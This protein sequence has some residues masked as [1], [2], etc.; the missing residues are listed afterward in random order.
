MQIS[1][2]RYLGTTGFGLASTL[3]VAC[4]TGQ[5]SGGEG[6]PKPAA[7]R[8]AIEWWSGWGA[9]GLHAD[10]FNKVADMANQVDGRSY[11]VHYTPQSSVGTKLPEVIAAGSPPDAHVGT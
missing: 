10:A 4:G 1:R 8:T 6:Q 2:R 5:G 11:D 3:A 7:Q 9:T